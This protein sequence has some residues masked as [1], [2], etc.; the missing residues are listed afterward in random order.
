MRQLEGTL[1]VEAL[2]QGGARLVIET[3][4]GEIL[5]L[6]QSP[7]QARLHRDAIDRVLQ[8]AAAKAVFAKP[9][10]PNAAPIPAPK[11]SAGK[12]RAKK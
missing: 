11:A 1:R 2:P 5:A 7:D 9:A 6:D 10:E 12:P 4:H 8:E 3:S